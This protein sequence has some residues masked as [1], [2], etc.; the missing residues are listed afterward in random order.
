MVLLALVTMPTW[1][2]E[3]RHHGGEVAVAP[4]PSPTA[5]PAP[6]PPPLP[7]PAQVAALDL[8]AQLH[9]RV[10]DR[11]LATERLRR[12]MAAHPPAHDPTLTELQ[13]Q[14]DCAALLL[15]YEAD[16]YRQRRQS[17]EAIAGYRRAIELF[18]QTHWADVARQ[19]LG[20]M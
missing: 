1:W 4:T 6:A 7:S 14:R 17:E 15:V 3:H 13:Q 10:A 5:A 19:R 18:P 2:R 8:E 12:R 16:R 20:N 9:E 11:L